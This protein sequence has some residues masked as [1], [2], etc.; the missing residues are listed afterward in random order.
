[1][2]NRWL[3]FPSVRTIG[4]LV[5]LVLLSACSTP[6]AYA[7]AGTDGRGYASQQVEQGR[8][9][10]SFKGNTLTDRET[11][12]AYLLYRAA[13]V[14]R[15]AGGDWF[16]IADQDTET[17]TRFSGQSLSVGRS[18]FGGSRFGHFGRFG[19]GFSTEFI[20]LRPR[21]SFEAFANVQVFRGRKPAD[22]PQAYSVQSVLRT[23]EPRIQRPVPRAG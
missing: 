4:V 17:I 21:R 9:T 5:C 3:L 7:P 15:D 19:G 6:T 18:S 12:E 11:V 1:M 10:V 14:S 8:F 22:D 23:L 16:R 2:S 20:D 13:E